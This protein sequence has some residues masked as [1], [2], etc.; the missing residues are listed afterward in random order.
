MKV[1][2]SIG[3]FSPLLRRPDYLFRGLQSTGADGVE[4]WIG[5]KSRW[6]ARYYRQLSRQYNVPI[7]SVHQPL[8]AMTGWYFDEGFF[9]V[10]QTL[11]VT[12]ITCHPLPNTALQSEKMQQY[13]KR[14]ATIQQRTGLRIL[15]ENMPKEYQNKLLSKTASLSGQTADTQAICHTA[16]AH[17][18]G[19]TL[20]TDH[21]HVAQPHNET[22]FNE[23]FPAIQNIHLSSF[24][25]D[26]RH[27]PLDT[28]T[29]DVAG[30]IKTLQKKHYDGLITLEVNAPKSI[31]LFT[32]KFDT[33]ERS[34]RLAR[35]L[36]SS[37]SDSLRRRSRS[38]PPR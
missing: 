12:Y 3:D 16:A 17:G 1:L 2:I 15:I 14:L 18:L 20:D 6:R 32:Y 29:L 11:G 21:A 24:D 19:V 7:V 5:V 26:R 38:L 13:F 22:W 28:G 25:G 10:A 8:W 9:K 27:Q 4:L 36:S 34:V 35:P 31:T 23:V 30:F 33:L 37:P